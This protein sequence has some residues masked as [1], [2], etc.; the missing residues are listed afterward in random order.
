MNRV[1][2]ETSQLVLAEEEKFEAYDVPLIRGEEEVERPADQRSITK[3]YTEEAVKQIRELKE[4]PFFIYLAHNLPHI[5][6]F[7]SA[8]FKDRSPAGIYGDV[9]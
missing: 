1:D 5:P 3:R 7:R 8:A 4:G 6:L 2:R 9:V